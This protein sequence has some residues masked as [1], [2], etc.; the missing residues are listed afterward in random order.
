PEDKGTVVFGSTATARNVFKAASEPAIGSVRTGALFVVREPFLSSTGH[1]L[2]TIEIRFRDRARK[3]GYLAKIAAEIQAKMARDTLSLK[4]A[5][6]PYPFDPAFGP[7][8][9]P[10]RLTE[11]TV[12]A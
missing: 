3:Q 4:N 5:I 9:Y 12:A 8:T 10:Q 11:K 7:S 1:R 2:G 6:E